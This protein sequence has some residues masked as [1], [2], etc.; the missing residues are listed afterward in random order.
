MLK[1]NGLLNWPP[2]LASMPLSSHSLLALTSSLRKTVKDSSA[3]ACM[4]GW[5]RSSHV[6]CVSWCRTATAASCSTAAHV[7]RVGWQLI[8]KV[9]CF[10]CLGVS[11][12]ETVQAWTAVRV[13]SAYTKGFP[14]HHALWAASSS[15]H[16]RY[17]PPRR[18]CQGQHCEGQTQS[19]AP[20]VIEAGTC[21]HHH[22]G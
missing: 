21:P 10:P 20:P 16:P 13:P 6:N 4:R 3:E 19:V 1:N 12:P 18:H 9:Q 5:R 14:S 11:V 17:G 15:L 8:A 7:L 2:S 22:A